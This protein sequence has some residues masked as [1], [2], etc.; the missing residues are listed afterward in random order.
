MFPN[1]DAEMARKRVKTY[2]G[3]DIYVVIDELADL[4][5]THRK[6]AFPLLQ[7]ICSWHLPH[8]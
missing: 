6:E 4:M 7:R 5:T 8:M 2:E 3:S 1:L